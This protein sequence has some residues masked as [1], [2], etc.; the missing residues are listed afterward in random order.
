M[1]VLVTLCVVLIG[2]GGGEDAS[3][4]SADTSPT[5][6]TAGADTSTTGDVSV[7]GDS[8]VPADVVPADVVAEAPPMGPCNDLALAPTGVMPVFMGG[9]APTSS[10]GTIADG[11][12]ELAQ[13]TQYS[14]SATTTKEYSTVR[15]TAGVID[16]V[17][18][19]GKSRASYTIDGRF[20]RLTYTCGMGP[21]NIAFTAGLSTFREY[22]PY[23]GGTRVLTYNKK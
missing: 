5:A 14:G 23:G 2:C 11:T 12:Y 16:R 19:F 20:L 13:V 4:T 10:G 21:T 3:G 18:L 9:S 8:G 15:F 7:A 22:V 1:R 6:E 17:D